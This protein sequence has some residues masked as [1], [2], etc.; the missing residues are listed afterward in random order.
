MKK[1]ILTVIVVAS[2]LLAWRA[3]RGGAGP[4]DG[5]HGP[6]I[7]YGRAW[8]DHMPKSRTEVFRVFGTGKKE[9]FGWFAERTAWKGTWEVFRYEPK[10]E[11]KADARLPQSGKTMR[12]GYRAWKCN[13]KDFD[14]CLE[15]SG[16][17]GPTK[18]YSRRGWERR[19]LDEALA[20]DAEL[21]P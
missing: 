6:E 13:E 21:A 20:L 9:P 15:L 17:D 8:I 7:F 3:W 1:L 14:Y 10:G 5:G 18:Y 2:G 4:A 19:G 12:L 16:L 11:G